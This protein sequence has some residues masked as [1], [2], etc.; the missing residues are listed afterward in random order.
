MTA[1]I[2]LHK[3]EYGVEPICNVLPIAPSTYD[4]KQVQGRD[5]SLRSDRARQD[6]E[7][8]PEIERV[9][10]ENHRVY[11][12]RR[13]GSSSAGKVMRWPGAR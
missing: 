4:T 13:C 11:G 5:P 12:V 7:L 2:D 1:F 9:W 10:D 6:D 3:G 8:L